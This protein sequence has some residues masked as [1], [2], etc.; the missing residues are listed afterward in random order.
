MYVKKVENELELEEA[1]KV[2]KKVFVEEQ[3]VPE[4]LELDSFD[5]SSTHFVLYAEDQPSGAGRFRLVDG[6]GKI[7]RVCVMKS[8][9]GKHAGIL[10]MQEVENYAKENGI[11]ALVL[12]AQTHALGFYEKLGYHVVSDEFMDAGI[13]HFKMQ[14]DL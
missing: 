2:R 10:L 7:E 1:F 13:P 3:H 6:K 4:E 8:L 9:R 5:P 14:K 11:S 12:N